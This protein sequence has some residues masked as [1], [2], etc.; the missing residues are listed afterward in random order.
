MCNDLFKSTKSELW[1]QRA[2]AGGHCCHPYVFIE[3]F[4]KAAEVLVS[5]ALTESKTLADLMFLFNPICYNYRHYIELHLKYLII[6]SE[7]LYHL[8]EMCDHTH[9]E[10]S[11]MVEPK[12][13]KYHRLKTLLDWLNERTKSLSGKGLDKEIK[14]IIVQLDDIDPDG[15]NFRYPHRTD[16]AQSHPRQFASD[17]KKLQTCM[18]KVHDY[19][20]ATG[21]WWDEDINDCSCYLS[22]ME[23]MGGYYDGF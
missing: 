15:Q 9:S 19:L 22:D 13:T 3:G 5:S 17:L 14:H 4:Y 20:S 2:T 11:E 23:Q 6:K 10:I 7:E 16:G 18:K 8:R 12:L 21:D 1:Y